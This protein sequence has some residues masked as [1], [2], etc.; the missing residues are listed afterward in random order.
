MP[1]PSIATSIS[2]MASYMHMPATNSTLHDSDIEETFM[3]GRERLSR[4]LMISDGRPSAFLS[5]LASLA[6]NDLECFKT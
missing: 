2:S 4:A 1:S 5:A 6:D 3:Y